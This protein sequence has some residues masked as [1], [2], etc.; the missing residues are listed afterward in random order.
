MN[1]DTHTTKYK[2]V[3]EDHMIFGQDVYYTR[4]SIKTQLNNN[5]VVV[6]TSGAGKTRGIVKPN[7]LQAS[8]S[9]VVSDPKG[10]LARE[11][12]PYLE[13][14]GYKIITMDFIHPEKSNRFNPITRC[15]NTS[16]IMKLAEML[17]YEFSCGEHHVDPFWDETTMLQLMALIG[18][19]HENR[20][21]KDD[22]STFLL[23]EKLITESVKRDSSCEG[24]TTI[25]RKKMELHDEKMRKRGE[26]SW[27]YRRFLEYDGCPE[28]THN[29]INICTIGKLVTFD[30]L[31]IRHM[32]SGNDL[33]FKKIGQ[34]KTA[35]FI[36]VSDTDRSKDILVNLFY[37]ML[38]NELC[39]YADSCEGSHLP[40]P[41]QFILDDFATNARIN[42]F[43][44][45]IANI[46]SRWIST[47]IMIQSEAQ[48]QAGFGNDSQ[49]IIDNCSTY[50]YMGSSDPMQAEKIA[51][52]ADR[53]VKEILN[54][55][56]GKS[57]I[58]RRGQEPVYCDNFD[59]EWFEHEKDYRN[60]VQNKEEK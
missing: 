11:I 10:N 34:E 12:G 57:W 58:F 24:R 32:L 54:M 23:V 26:E 55:P 27:A 18:Y 4:D 7:L 44:N 51:R 52:R 33:D 9:Y 40:V 29:T 1:S 3:P 48:L 60:P 49:T 13:E 17:V 19:I 2:P 39:D 5:V 22:D 20:A 25:L 6:G 21:I 43:E 37:S 31:E 47:M 56:I 59:L 35:L 30:T 28:K 36:Q 53:P 50:V 46:R 38:M 42:H 14:K 41:V 15:R 16:D 45:I 8:G